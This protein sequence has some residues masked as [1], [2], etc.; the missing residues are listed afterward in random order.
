VQRSADFPIGVP[1]NIAS[2]A[3]LTHMIAHVCGLEVGDLVYNFN[4]AHIYLNQVDALQ[5]QLKREPY[6]LPK[7]WLN[8]EVKDIDS[9]KFED[10][11]LV[12]YQHHPAIKMEVC[13]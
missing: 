3:L 6:P 13:V 11:K 7:L 2:Y 9:F 1:V 5:E 10:I 12:G 4:D 8:P